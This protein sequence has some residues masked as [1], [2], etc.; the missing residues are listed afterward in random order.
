M[1]QQRATRQSK[2][3]SW[4]AILV[5]TLA[6]LGLLLGAAS[7][8]A[9]QAKK[10]SVRVSLKGEVIGVSPGIIRAKAEGKPYL[11][12]VNED[13]NTLT[14]TGTILS[15]QLKAGLIVRCTGMLKGNALAEELTELT[16]HTAADGYQAN[17]LQDGPNEPATIIGRLTR[18]KD[19]SLVIAAGRKTISA[20]L[21]D[22]AKILVDTKD[23][24][25]LK[26]GEAVHFDGQV[27][28]DGK[29]VGCR[30]IT[31]TIGQ[32]AE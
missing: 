16:V 15:D 10:K 32:K 25:V 8:A 28:S 19:K 3:T 6:I 21:A 27:A 4:L 26:G 29:T 20:R 1:L 30:K 9:A 22:D 5:A 31:I 14:I 2:P 24:S 23:Y 7:P 17:V 18:V 13:R 11:L 12:K